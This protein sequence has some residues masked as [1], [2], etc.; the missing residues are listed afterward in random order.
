MMEP[1]WQKRA[2]QFVDI[3]SGD[4]NMTRYVELLITH[5]ISAKVLSGHGPEDRPAGCGG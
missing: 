4:L 1:G 5:G 3:G 2:M